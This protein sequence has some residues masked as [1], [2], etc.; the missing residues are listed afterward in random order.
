MISIRRVITGVMFGILGMALLTVAMTARAGT[1]ELTWQIPLTYCDGTA[2]ATP[3]SYTLTYGQKKETLSPGSL[4][5][6]TVT[7][8]SP[9][10][11]W[12]SLAA[13]VG[14]EQ[15]QFVTVEK[16]V[17][18]S[19]FSVAQSDAFA[20]VKRVDRLVLAKVGTVPVGTPCLADQTINGKYVVPRS[21]VTWSGSVKPDVVVATC[22]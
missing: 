6:H 18:A 4:V 12:F 21:L 17:L 19:E 9:G 5:S 11:W 8:L 7:G 22:H 3:D 1:A 10:L 16:T 13:N 15:S 20:L 2:M 14:T